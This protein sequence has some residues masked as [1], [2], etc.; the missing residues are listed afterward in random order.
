MNRNG[1]PRNLLILQASLVSLFG[2]V[3][4][5]VPGVNA[6]FWMLLDLTMLIYLTMYILMFL[7]AIRLR[8]TQPDVTRTYKVP[9]GKVGMWLIGGLGLV[10]VLFTMVI[11]F[12]PPEQLAMGSVTTYHMFLSV[13]LVVVVVIPLIIYRLRKPGWLVSGENK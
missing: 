7:A 4:A 12:F 6:A 3:F 11:S 8:Y 9:G 2:V 1:I 10:T 5:L 13:G